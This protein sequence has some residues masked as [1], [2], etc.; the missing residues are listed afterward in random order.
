MLRIAL[1][2]GALVAAF[3]GV[4]TAGAAAQTAARPAPSGD[5]RAPPVGLEIE[6]EKGGRLRIVAVDGLDITYRQPGGQV[7][8]RHTPFFRQC[9]HQAC[10]VDPSPLESLFPLALGNTASFILSRDQ[11][12]WQHSYEVV[13]AETMPIGTEVYDVW[14]VAHVEE[15]LTGRY[16][17]EERYYYAPAVGF[18]VRVEQ[19]IATGIEN[20]R[21][22]RDSWYA[23]A[24]RRPE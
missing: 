20:P 12:R 8:V 24:V 14:V 17:S 3:Y 23:V 15:S 16:R 10:R 4:A 18:I 2:V 1:L 21:N 19:Y 9:Q 5:Y 22:R 6:N 7:A 11:M 13:G